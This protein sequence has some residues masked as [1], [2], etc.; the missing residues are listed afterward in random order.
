[1]SVGTSLAGNGAW[2]T[3]GWLRLA[4]L[5]AAL[6]VIAVQT[7]RPVDDPD[8]WWHLR[9]GRELVK[10]LVFVGPDPWSPFTTGEWIRH[11]WLGDLLIWSVHSAADLA[12]V[13]WLVA[14]FS[15]VATTTTYF[16]CRRH[17]PVLVSAAVSV[18]AFVGMSMSLTARPQSLS[19]A[20]TVLA[21]GAWLST[22]QDRRPRWWLVPLTWLWAC[23]HGFWIVA[24]VLGGVVVVALLLERAPWREVLRLAALPVGCGVA[25][26][27][28]PV[29]PRLLLAPFQIS[30]VTGYVEEWDPPTVGMP[31]FVATALMAAC[32]ALLRTVRATPTWTEVGMLLSAVFLLIIHGRTVALAAAVLAPLLAAALTHHL[33]LGR[34]RLRPSEILATAAAAVVGLVVAGVA[35]VAQPMASEG[36]PTALSAELDELPRGTVVCNDYYTGGWLWFTHPTLVPVIDG[37]TELY[38]PAELDAY[39]R[40]MAGGAGTIDRATR[41]DCDAALVET[42]SPPASTLAAD[43]WAVVSADGW[44]LLTAQPQR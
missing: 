9:T 28:T 26:A 18:V 40:F 39:V 38:G 37:R 14:A 43:G 35:A 3:P 25:A 5:L 21:A 16:V 13:S 23:V 33:P 20:F 7:V 17:A 1:M 4:P 6:V 2:R 34:E 41:R 44:S 22:S 31:A 36:F 11:E 10:D 15:V 42:G 12:G 24:P 30:P 27:L 29:G 32:I 19:F 8:T